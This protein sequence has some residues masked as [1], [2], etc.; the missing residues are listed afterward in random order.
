MLTG[1]SNMRQPPGL[2]IRLQDVL[3]VGRREDLTF[4]PN[5]TPSSDFPITILVNV[6]AH[7]KSGDTIFPL[8]RSFYET[9][10]KDIAHDITCEMCNTEA[11]IEITKIGSKIALLVTKWIN[12]GPGITPDDIL[13]RAHVENPLMLNTDS[14]CIPEDLYTNPRLFFERAALLAFK[15]LG[16]RNL[17]ILRGREYLTSP[18]FR[19]W[20]WTNDMWLMPFQAREHSEVANV[21]KR[22]SFLRF[23]PRLA[24]L[25][26]K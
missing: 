18:S 8:V 14:E 7:M 16:S 4:D 11:H 21:P 13:W 15:D 23:L 17:A 12:L 2:Y 1:C 5:D 25:S 6:C 3:L 20:P 22:R 9:E 19:L 26:G 24:D 10:E